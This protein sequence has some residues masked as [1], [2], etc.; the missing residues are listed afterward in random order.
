MSFMLKTGAELQA[1]RREAAERFTA[2]A[3]QSVPEGWTIEYHK[4]LSGWCFFAEK[5]IQAP[6]PVTRKALYIF[7]HECAHAHLHQDAI[8]ERH[9]E[10]LE[11]ERWAHERMRE[12][13]I[14]V[15]RSQTERAKQNVARQIGRDVADGATRIDPQVRRWAK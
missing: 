11:A 4:S 7:L 1:L 6:R 13:G 5:K 2:I 14:A 12:H 10:E 9:V 8:R 3:M 15:P